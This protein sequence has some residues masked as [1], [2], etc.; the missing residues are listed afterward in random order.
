MMEL[1]GEKQI[2]PD[3]NNNKPSYP[4]KEKV[5]LTTEALLAETTWYDPSSFL[6]MFSLLLKEL[7]FYFYLPLLQLVL[8]RVVAIKRL[9]IHQP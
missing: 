4:N 6:W 2:Y 3:G 8:C 1:L 5:F 7:I 9:P